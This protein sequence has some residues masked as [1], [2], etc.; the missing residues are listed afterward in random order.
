MKY[1]F[2]KL[3]A[4]RIENRLTQTELAAQIGVSVAAISTVESGKGPW[5]KVIREM[6]KALGIDGVIRRPV[7]RSA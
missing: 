1:D 2:R 3:K 7:K 5:L 4:A 6:E